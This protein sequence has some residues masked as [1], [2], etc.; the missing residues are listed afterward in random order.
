M[1]VRAEVLRPADCNATGRVILN[2]IINQS[3]AGGVEVSVSPCYTGTAEWLVI[4]GVGAP[5]RSE[6]RDR[7]IAA[8]GK[9]ALWD[10][11]FFKRVKLYG[12]CKVSVNDDYATRWLDRTE[13]LPQRWDNLGLK[14]RDDADPSGH[15]VLAGIGPKHHAYLAGKIDNWERDKFKELSRRFPNRRIVYRPKPLRRYVEMLGVE[16]DP[17]SP[18]ENVLRGAALVVCYHSNVAVDAVLAGVPFEAEDGVSTWLKDKPYT[19]ET[20]L[21]FVRR[22]ARWQYKSTEMDQAWRFLLEVTAG[23]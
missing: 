17:V 19:M 7:H 6:I 11:G 4:W 9:V 18:I 8:G 16:M 2:S 13:P 3:A 20:R 10:I 22:I 12:H 15:I 21:D 5:G 14:L 1:A 23:G